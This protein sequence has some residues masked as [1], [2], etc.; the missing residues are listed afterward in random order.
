MDVEKQEEKED[1]V[2]E[3]NGSQDREAHIARAS[4]VEMHMDMSQEPFCVESSGKKCR[5]PLPRHKFCASMRGQNAHGHLR[6]AILFGN[7]V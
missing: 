4:A 3:E 6:R 5:T 1:D 2:E 7:F